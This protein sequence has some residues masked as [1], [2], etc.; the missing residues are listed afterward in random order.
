MARHVV[1]GRESSVT[2]TEMVK[3]PTKTWAKVPMKA[4]QTVAK[5]WGRSKRWWGR[6]KRWWRRG[7]GEGAR[8][9]SEGE[10]ICSS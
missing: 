3:G 8:D 4:L 7:G 10:D 9:G 1:G 6:S 5:G 2:A